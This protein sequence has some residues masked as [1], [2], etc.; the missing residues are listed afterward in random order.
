MRYSA[1]NL[2]EAKDN[3]NKFKI[4][5]DSYHRSAAGI[6]S[7]T[8]LYIVPNKSENSVILTTINPKSWGDIWRIDADH[9]N[10]PGAFH[11]FVSLL[12]KRSINILPFEST[13]EQFQISGANVFR[14]TFIV[15]LENYD[16]EID[17]DTEYRNHLEKPYLIPFNL[18]NY[19]ATN[20]RDLLCSNDTG[21]DWLLN[22]QR[23]RYYFDHKGIRDDFIKKYWQKDGITF[24]KAELKALL[25]NLSFGDDL[26][27]YITSDTENKYAK[28]FFLDEASKPMLSLRVE[29]REN[30]GVVADMTEVVAD[31]N[32]NIECT[33][34]RLQ[35]MG[36]EAYWNALLS[37]RGEVRPSDVIKDIALLPSVISADVKMSHNLDR[38]NLAN[39]LNPL[40]KV[41]VVKRTSPRAPETISRKFEP[42][43]RLKPIHVGKEY[44]FHSTQAFMAMPFE[45]DFDA[46]FA[47]VIVPCTESVGLRA[48]HAQIPTE[49]R[50]NE[51]LIERIIRMIHESS[52][53]IADLSHSNANV[54]YELAI[55]HAIGRPVLLICDTNKTSM[56]DLPFDLKSQEVMGYRFGYR[57]RLGDKLCA[58]LEGLGFRSRG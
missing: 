15:D 23:M 22:I 32:A 35:E 20:S 48:V 8:A 45:E 42:D 56:S 21:S 12:S 33:Y 17:R 39:Q 55:A 47:D 24:K 26:S 13:S 1:D 3:E 53:L 27:Y 43:L 4:P 58:R 9:H 57:Q 25:P 19:I 36:K 29:H 31:K 49:V 7:N 46:V 34:N 51:A 37:F 54:C 52:L 5:I 50:P 11:R 16:D 38:S 41:R 2:H 40:P 10:E 14:S 28:I 6:F 30:P 18:K 44:K